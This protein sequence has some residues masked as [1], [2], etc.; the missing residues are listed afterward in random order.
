MELRI[1]HIGYLTGDIEKTAKLFEKL[2]YQR[3]GEAIPDET[4]KT[5]ICYLQKGD[6]VKVELVEPFAENEPML[7][8]LKLR[9][10]SPYHICYEVDDIYEAV[11]VYQK[12]GWVQM[13]QPV[14][15]PASGNKLISYFYKKGIGYIE[16]VNKD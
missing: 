9:G 16:F 1:D 6:E 15:A 12:E 3:L 11:E 7:K 10:V 8:M 14:I 4:Q 5:L 13:F 2:G